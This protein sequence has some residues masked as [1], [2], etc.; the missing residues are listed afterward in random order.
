MAGGGGPGAG[1]GPIRDLVQPGADRVPHPQPARPLHQD[2]ERGLEG[3]LR[4]VR[5]RQHAA[6][7]PHHHRAVPLDQ[8]GEG[9]LGGLAPVGREPLQELAVGQLAARRRR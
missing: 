8:D 9:Q 6:A 4:V 3:V 2:Q 1:R 7:D 5:V